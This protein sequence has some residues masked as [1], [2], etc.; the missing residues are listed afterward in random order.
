MD[1]ETMPD[2]ILLA[3]TD[4][5]LDDARTLMR[6]FVAWHRARHV[7]DISLINRYFDPKAF[8]A[9]L[10]GLPGKYAPPHGALLLA[11]QDGA[12]AGCVALRNLGVGICEMKRMYVAEGFRELGIGRALTARVIVEA[13]HAGYRAMRLDTSKRQSE[14]IR[15]Y[16]RAGFRRIEPY[17]TLPND[18]Q[19]DDLR[20]WLVFFELELGK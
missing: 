16:E 7:E 5:E 17:Y 9:E 12:A 1:R 3:T 8:E 13:R 20:D 4:T 19:A 2:G 10:A 15:L 11:Y 14:A 6:D 18:L